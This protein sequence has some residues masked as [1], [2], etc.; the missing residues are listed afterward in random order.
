MLDHTFFVYRD[1]TTG[2]ISV[3]YKRED[4]GYGV[5]EAV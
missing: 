5:I 4:G 2:I 3:L 1:A